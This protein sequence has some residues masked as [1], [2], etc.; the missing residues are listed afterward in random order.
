MHAHGILLIHRAPFV[1]PNP[2]YL[3]YIGESLETLSRHKTQDYKTIL[4]TPVDTQEEA[5]EQRIAD[6]SQREGEQLRTPK[7]IGYR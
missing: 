5:A 1:T 4:T 7:A 6:N 3:D 2:Q